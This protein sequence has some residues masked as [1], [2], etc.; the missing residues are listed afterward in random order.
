MCLEF[1]VKSSISIYELRKQKEVW[2]G[3]NFVDVEA[4]VP[5]S[6]SNAHQIN[7]LVSRPMRIFGI[8]ELN[9]LTP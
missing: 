8:K 2:L 9:Y 7:C 1:S 5:I 4:I 3:K 6:V